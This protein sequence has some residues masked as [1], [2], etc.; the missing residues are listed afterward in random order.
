MSMSNEKRFVLCMVLMVLWMLAWPYLARRMG[1]MSEPKKPP[2]DAVLAK[3]AEKKEEPAAKAEGAAK[4]ET[5]KVQ[6]PAKA[7]AQAA[8]TPPKKPEV[9]LVQRVRARARGGERS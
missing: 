9:E 7:L 2:V 6:E 4:P 8:E 1:L 5:P 3:D